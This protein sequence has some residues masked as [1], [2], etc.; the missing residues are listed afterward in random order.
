MKKRPLLFLITS[1][2]SL[3][4]FTAEATERLN[5][6]ADF[7]EKDELLIEM[8]K[9][10]DYGYSSALSAAFV[11][12]TDTLYL[13]AGDGIDE[14]SLYEIAS[15]T[16]SFTAHLA[17]LLHQEGIIDIHQPLKEIHPAVTIYHLLTHSSGINDPEKHNEY[18]RKPSNDVVASDMTEK[19]MLAYVKTTQLA[20]QPGSDILYSN[21][22]YALIAYKL[23]QATNQTFE[24]LLQTRILDPLGMHSTFVKL[25]KSE[26]H[27]MV[28]GTSEGRKAPYW[29]IPHLHG[30]AEMISCTEDLKKY[31]SYLFFSPEDK[32]LQE[33]KALLFQPFILNKNAPPAPLP[34]LGW[35]IDRRYGA[36]L[37]GGGGTSSGFTS[38]IGYV[39]KEKKALIILNNSS[40]LADLG[41]HFLDSR[42]PIPQLRKVVPI[43]L[44]NLKKYEGLY[45]FN[46]GEEVCVA[47]I[48]AEADSCLKMEPEGEG[49]RF[50][51]PYSEDGFFT[52]FLEVPKETFHFITDDNNN[53]SGITV[54]DDGVELFTA[55]K[56][57]E[58]SPLN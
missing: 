21:L 23:E 5:S 49:P 28:Q 40:Y 39:E 8:Q 16:K 4:T 29:H 6:N 43:S 3:L 50:L 33:L 18:D 7:P 52:K 37:M 10:V 34:L 44:A 31:V 45:Q 38:F 1:L 51:Y 20:F 15:I 57:S 56:L 54:K 35:V 55:T 58:L 17:C 14:H 32:K 46:L 26:S 47:K 24:Q 22:A 25:P 30:F 11:N 53:I 13:N 27:R 9:R 12:P 2:M 41:A 48:T 42:I 19:E 36:S